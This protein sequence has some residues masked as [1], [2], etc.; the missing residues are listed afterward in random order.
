MNRKIAPDLAGKIK[1]TR[2][3]GK[4][5]QYLGAFSFPSLLAVS[6]Y[7]SLSVASSQWSE[8]NFHGDLPNIRKAHSLAQASSQVI[9]QGQEISLNGRKFPVAWSQWQEGGSVRTGISDTGAMQILGLV[10]LS[11]RSLSEQ[12]VEWF[13]KVQAKPLV[14]KV[15]RISPYRYLDITDVAKLAGVRL[16]ILGSTLTIDSPRAQI[17]NIRQGRQSWGKRIVVDLDRPTFW[18]VSQAKS[19]GVVMIEGMATPA[20]LAQFQ[21]PDNSLFT[22]ENTQTTTKLR[23]NLPAANGYG[24][25]IF[26][27]SN[28]NRLVIDIRPDA[29]IPR[30]IVWAPGIT[31]HQQFVKLKKGFGQDSFPVTWLEVDLRSPKISLK[32]ITS[33]PNQLEGIA[34][35]LTTARLGQ[36][37]AAINGGFFN[38]DNQ[39]PLGA[40]R[41]DGRW[42]SSP[43]LNRGAIA[44]D[45]Q[46]NVKIGRLSLKET[47]TTST[48]NR[49][50]IL[51]LNS[52]YVQAGIARYTREWGKA[53]TPLTDRETIVLVQN[54]RVTEQLAAGIAGERS[55]SIPANGYLLTIRADGAPAKNLAA[56]A[57]VNLKSSVVPADFAGYPQILGAGPLLLQNR[58]IVLNAKGEKFNQAFQRQKASRSAIATTNRKTLIIAAVHNRAGGKGPSLTELAQILQRLGAIDALNLDGGSSTSLY[59]GGQLI[60]RSPVTAARVHNG[61]GVFINP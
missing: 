8:V 32:P 44:W 35:L 17:K 2:R 38:R 45:N 37:A 18:Q 12:P 16:Q 41:R 54:N 26:S 25:R 53:Y 6:I 47:L 15:Q 46:G 7:P 14:L 11:T 33:N 59:L 52:G 60:D 27:L 1:G 36:A 40:I 28:P 55:F 48:G 43:I 4:I 51:F 61:I 5:W 30:E 19:E 9:R 31:W 10:L 39:L 49:L 29:M 42:L 21:R 23:I 13:S 56:N 24:L 22:L 3:Q 34:P 58:Q 20:L 57:R 50:P